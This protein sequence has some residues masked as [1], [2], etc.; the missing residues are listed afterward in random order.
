MK[1]LGSV[2]PSFLF[3]LGCSGDAAPTATSSASLPAGSA[4]RAGS[5]LI[6][7]ATI[8]RIAQSQG[9]APRDAV[10]LAVSDALFAEAAKAALPSATTRSIERAA[11]ARSLLEQ[12]SQQAARAG[13]PTSHERAEILRDR[14][15]ELDRPAGARTTHAVVLNEK[16]EL[17]AGAH[18]LAD[19]LFRALQGVTS[20]DELIR[21]ANALPAG[22]FKIRAEGLPFVTPDGR[23]FQ[24]VGSGFRG[25]T[26]TFDP[27]FARAAS[28]IALPGELS[29][30]SKSAFGYH[31]IRLEERLPGATV[32]EPELSQRIARETLVR[33]AARDRRELLEKLRQTS[34]VQ[35]ERAFDEL[36]AQ[37][38]AAP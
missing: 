21:L 34:S 35:L 6:S 32:P 8:T 17:D 3:A 18:A 10:G 11:V 13:P 4:A 12:F 29:P 9:V 22:S 37:V 2:V 30:V 24:P 26:S 5:E 23:A 7:T 19:K 31:V 36:T 20:G 33:R 28:A 1:A 14:W 38:K 15:L 25:G 16:P 27:D